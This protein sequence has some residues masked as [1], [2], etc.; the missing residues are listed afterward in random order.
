M[1][2]PGGRDGGSRELGTALAS[3]EKCGSRAPEGEMNRGSRVQGWVPRAPAGVW[4]EELAALTSQ[5]A[6]RGRERSRGE[7]DVGATACGLNTRTCEPTTQDALPQCLGSALAPREAGGPGQP[8]PDPHVAA[9][10]GPCFPRL[11]GPPPVPTPCLAVTQPTAVQTLPR[12]LGWEPGLSSPLCPPLSLL[13][14]SF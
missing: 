6:S 3:Q 5:G 8:L 2:Q 13:S 7:A 14:R 11:L 4:G 9:G 12:S 1:T 10:H